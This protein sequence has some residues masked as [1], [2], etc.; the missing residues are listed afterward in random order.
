VFILKNHLDELILAE[1][2]EKC[3]EYLNPIFIYLF[4]SGVQ[5]TMTDESDLDLAFLSKDT[6][7][8]YELLMFSQ[9]LASIAK[10]EI[11]LIDLAYASTVFRAQIIGKGKAIYSND[12][13]FMYQYEIRALKEYTKLNEERKEIIDRVIKEKT[14][15]G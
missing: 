13:N 7:T 9:E 3:K 15:Y 1:I 6:F 8:G 10:R 4:G 2:I 14:I 12:K 11:D 5:G